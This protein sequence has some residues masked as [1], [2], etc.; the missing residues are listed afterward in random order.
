MTIA[1]AAAVLTVV[2][3]HLIAPS[4]A[5]RLWPGNVDRAYCAIT[6]LLALIAVLA[7]ALAQLPSAFIVS[8][9]DPVLAVVAGLGGAALPLAAVLVSSRLGHRQRA[10]GPKLTAPW[11]IAAASSEEVLWRVLA[12]AAA[13][14]VGW[15]L[16]VG[17]SPPRRHTPRT[18]WSSPEIFI[19]TRQPAIEGH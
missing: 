7:G 11:V 9:W 12:P 15:Q 4:T 8:R 17:Y 5:W 19:S 16:P 3:L 6:G 13:H 18:T 10:H 2:E 1:G 14:A